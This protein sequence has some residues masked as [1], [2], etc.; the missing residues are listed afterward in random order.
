MLRY[1]RGLVVAVVGFLTVTW[2]CAAQDSKGTAEKL[3]EKVGSAVKSVEK[4]VAGAKESV[5]GQYQRTR[6]SIHNMTVE[7]RVYGRL[8]WDKALVGSKIEL[9]AGKQDGVIIV[10]GTVADARAK[11]KA[12]ELTADTVGVT[13]VVNELKV[14]SS[15]SSAPS[16]KSTT[17]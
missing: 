1:S 15:A 11:A 4:G 9:V 8:H 2:V 12:I 14:L 5:R 17:P 16:P 3:K 6:E 13:Q 10:R 7:H